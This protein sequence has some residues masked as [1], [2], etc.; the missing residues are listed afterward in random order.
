MR[1][2][3]KKKYYRLPKIQRFTELGLTRQNKGGS[4]W[5]K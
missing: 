5:M 4:F 2:E 3:M 1:G